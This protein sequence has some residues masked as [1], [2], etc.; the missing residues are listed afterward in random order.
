MPKITTAN[1]ASGFHG[2]DPVNL[3]KTIQLALDND[4][5]IGCR[6]GFSD[7]LGFGRRCMTIGA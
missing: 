5:W 7:L 3:L 2:G 1:I 4:V 6:P